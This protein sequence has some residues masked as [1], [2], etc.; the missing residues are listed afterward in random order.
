MRATKLRRRCRRRRL[1]SRK[2][3]RRRSGV[4]R[5][6]YR[7][8]P[9]RSCGGCSSRLGRNVDVRA[10]DGEDYYSEFKEDGYA[11]DDRQDGSAGAARGEFCRGDKTATRPGAASNAAKAAAVPKFAVPEFAVPELAVPGLKAAGRGPAVGA[12]D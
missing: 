8:W 6:K 5:S 10:Q 7:D 11:E 12:P 9:R 1:T 3:G 2:I 4:C